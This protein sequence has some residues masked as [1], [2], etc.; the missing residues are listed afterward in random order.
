MTGHCWNSKQTKA[1]PVHA[2]PWKPGDA[3][4]GQCKGVYDMVGPTAGESGKDPPTSEASNQGG[5]LTDYL[6]Y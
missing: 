4:K 5:A 3:K 2:F 6:S 1:L